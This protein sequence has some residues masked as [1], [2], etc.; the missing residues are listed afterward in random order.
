METVTAYIGIGSNL[1][2]PADQVGRALQELANM[3]YSICRARSSLYRSPPMGPPD[4]PEYVNAV[5]RLDTGLSPE[6][7]LD[8]GESLELA[9]V[10]FDVVP[11]PG[12]SPGH[13]AFA[14]EGALL[15]GDVLFAGSVGRTDLPG[16]DWETLLASLRVLVD[17]YPGETV[18]YPGHG[19]ATTLGDELARNPFLADLRREREEAAG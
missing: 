11:V 10:S 1:D 8:G 18:V 17:G 12:H 9:G 7:L 15:A 4:Q 19:P 6:V 14:V 3:P 16:A 2:G 13:L 5:A